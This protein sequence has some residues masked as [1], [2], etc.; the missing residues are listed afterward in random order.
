MNAKPEVRWQVQ[1]R[2]Q[3]GPLALDVEFE[4]VGPALLIG[5]NGAGKSTLLRAI[6][7]ARTPLIGRVQLGSLTLLDSAARF[8]LAP[9]ARAL[10]YVPQ[11]CALFEHLTVLQNVAFGLRGD[12]AGQQARALAVLAKVQADHL[13]QRSP[14]ALSGGER[15]RVALARAL[16]PSPAGLLLDEPLAALDALSRRA[17]RRFLAQH[18]QQD[19]RPALVVTHDVRDVMAIGG[20]VLVLEGGRIVQKGSP[21]ELGQRPGSAFVEEFFEMVTPGAAKDAGGHIPPTA[22]D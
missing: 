10:G 3:L 8:D 17:T 12:R 13:A 19:A 4:A 6:A 5:P 20:Q 2:G 7:G 18:L 9:E 15:Q 11:G 1:L 16:A 14:K 22:S 21:H